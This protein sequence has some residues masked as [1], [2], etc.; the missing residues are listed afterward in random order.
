MPKRQPH[1]VHLI[2]CTLLF[3]MLI[4][5]QAQSARCAEIDSSRKGAVGKIDHDLPRWIDSLSG[6]RA[7]SQPV[8]F[9]EGGAMSNLPQTVIDQLNMDEPPMT[10]SNSPEFKISTVDGPNGAFGIATAG[11]QKE[12]LRYLY[13]DEKRS[14]FF[15]ADIESTPKWTVTV[16]GTSGVHAGAAQME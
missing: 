11:A 4:T 9:V 3:M 12:G 15:Y 6:R 7:F 13:R 14:F 16:L 2:G 5:E 8:V 10:E 1:L